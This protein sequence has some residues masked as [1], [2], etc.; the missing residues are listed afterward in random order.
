MT[1][2]FWINFENSAKQGKTVVVMETCK[3]K[4]EGKKTHWELV[5]TLWSNQFIKQ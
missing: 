4:L 1:N 2:M 5:T 3:R